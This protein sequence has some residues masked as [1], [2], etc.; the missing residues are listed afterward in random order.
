MRGIERRKKAHLESLVE[1][2]QALKEEIDQKHQEVLSLRQGMG[3][4]TTQYEQYVRALDKQ[5]REL[6]EEIRHHRYR[7]RRFH[8][9]DSDLPEIDEVQ[10]EMPDETE[11]IPHS[12]DEPLPDF[13]TSRPRE[14]L[15]AEKAQVRKHFAHFWHPDKSTEKVLMT[16]VNVAFD[17]SQDAVDMMI[18]IPWNE[19]WVKPGEKENWQH[20][21]GRLTEWKLCLED[22]RERVEQRLA[23]LTQDWQH[24]QYLEWRKVGKRPDYFAA[25]ATRQRKEITHLEQTLETLKAELAHLERP[26]GESEGQ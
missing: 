17:E 19:A 23:H 20:Q 5:H 6:E 22:A 25:L 9:Q 4:F 24:S 2:V 12:E 8:D 18:I 10:E 16:T 14:S 1:K 7:I 13:T 3:A 21:L 11:E 26:A 15:E